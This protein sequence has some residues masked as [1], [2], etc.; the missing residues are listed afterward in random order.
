[1]ALRDVIKEGDKLLRQKSKEVKRFD[2][3]LEE[4]L[5]DMTETMRANNGVGLAAPQVGILKKIVVI[6][7]NGLHLEL[8]NPVITH[9]QGEEI[10]RE[11]CLSV[12]GKSG[13]VARP[14]QV[15]VKAQDRLGYDYTLTCEDWLARCVCHELDHLDGI[16]YIDKIIE[17][18]QPPQK[19]EIE[20]EE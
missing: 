9:M 16:L 5:A 4:L 18:Y 10:A 3:K 20:E 2:K 8:I 14:T 17:G 6:E 11:G 13:W 1:M 12:P 19:E 7:I 15:T